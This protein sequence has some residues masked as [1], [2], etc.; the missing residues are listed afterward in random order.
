MERFIFMTVMLREE[1]VRPDIKVGNGF[2]NWKLKCVSSLYSHC[3]S[4]EIHWPHVIFI[5]MFDRKKKTKKKNN[6]K[7]K[8]P[9]WWL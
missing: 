3:Q 4:L 7:K 1:Q 9:F 2:M 8:S 6:L 5:L